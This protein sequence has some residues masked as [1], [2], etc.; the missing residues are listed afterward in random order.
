MS[1]IHDLV[2]EHFIKVYCNIA[3]VYCIP[4]VSLYKVTKASFGIVSIS[5]SNCSISLVYLNIHTVI[6]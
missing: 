2:D 6:S 1:L 4:T 3:D 5:T